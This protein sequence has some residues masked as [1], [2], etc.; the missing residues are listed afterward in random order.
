[1]AFNRTVTATTTFSFRL[2]GLL[3]LFRKFSRTWNDLGIIG[4]I[5]FQVRMSLL[6]LSHQCQNIEGKEY[7]SRSDISFVCT[8]KK[9]K[10]ARCVAKAHLT[11]SLNLRQKGHVFDLPRCT[12]E[13][14]TKNHFCHGV[15]LNSAKTA[16]NCLASLFL[17]VILSCCYRSLFR[18]VCYF[19]HQSI[20]SFGDELLFVTVTERS[21]TDETAG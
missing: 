10:I 4:E 14:H 5:F 9:A 17:N 6:S 11:R 12:L 7:F 20:M 2:T 1:M 15:C 18:Y 3:L 8:V 13:I 16:F 19:N 21:S